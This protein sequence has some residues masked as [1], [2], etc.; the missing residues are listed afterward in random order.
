MGWLFVEGRAGRGVSKLLLKGERGVT[1]GFVIVLVVGKVVGKRVANGTFCC[2]VVIIIR[3]L[4][5]SKF[6]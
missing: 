5:E 4:W 3:F 6:G 2:L 1:L